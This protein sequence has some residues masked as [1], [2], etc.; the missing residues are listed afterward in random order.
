MHGQIPLSDH[1]QPPAT[2][3]ERIDS[4]A[5]CSVGFDSYNVENPE[6]PGRLLSSSPRDRGHRL[7]GAFARRE[8]AVDIEVTG[9][10]PVGWQVWDSRSPHYHLLLVVTD[11]RV[12]WFYDRKVTNYVLPDGTVIREG[13]QH[14]H[15]LSV[16]YRIKDHYREQYGLTDLRLQFHEVSRPARGRTARR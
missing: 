8:C 9:A 13:T 14:S 4:R 10:V 6:T 2:T 15:L 5:R 1:G 7:S 3:W 11:V 16:H 12:E